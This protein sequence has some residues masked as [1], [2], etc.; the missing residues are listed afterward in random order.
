MKRFAFFAVLLALLL[1]CSCGKAD[2][3]I[4]TD[5]SGAKTTDYPA[6]TTTEAVFET[7]E[8]GN[9][10]AVLNKSSG[11]FHLSQDC[12]HAKRMKEENRQKKRKRSAKRKNNK[13]KKKNIGKE[14][15]ENRENREETDDYWLDE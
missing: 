12:Y 7:D 9:I 4:R 10:S 5:M 11:V 14:K 13:K 6:E 1:L 2:I 15:R 8:S 3:I